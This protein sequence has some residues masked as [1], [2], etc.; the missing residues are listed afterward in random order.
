MLRIWRSVAIVAECGKCGEVWRSVVECGESG[1]CGECD[2]VWRS[3][4][5]AVNVSV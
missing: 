3:I 2:G 5:T 1:E 4:A